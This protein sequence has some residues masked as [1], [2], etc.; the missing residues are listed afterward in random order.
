MGAIGVDGHEHCCLCGD[1]GM[2]R[3]NET[4][5][6]VCVVCHPKLHELL[7]GTG[8]GW[9]WV[10]QPLGEALVRYRDYV[11]AMNTED[12]KNFEIHDKF[13]KRWKASQLGGVGG[14]P[15]SVCAVPGA[16]VSLQSA[17]RTATTKRPQRSQRT[18]GR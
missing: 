14:D 6:M 3:D 5:H 7:E 17:E 16:S 8:D 4:A 13:N 15:G 1:L 2:Y 12:P 9:I 18:E 10:S 11:V